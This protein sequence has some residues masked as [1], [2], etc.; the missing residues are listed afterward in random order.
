MAL[1]LDSYRQARRMAMAG[2][3]WIGCQGGVA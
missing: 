3:G 2:S 1:T